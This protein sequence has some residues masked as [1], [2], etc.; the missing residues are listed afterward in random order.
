VYVAPDPLT[1]VVR[2]TGI[3]TEDPQKWRGVFLDEDA[4]LPE[5]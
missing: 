1:A 5:Q 2:G 4:I 3:I